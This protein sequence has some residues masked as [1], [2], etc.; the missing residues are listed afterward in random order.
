MDGL[1]PERAYIPVLR[2]FS[3]HASGICFFLK[4]PDTAAC[5]DC[6]KC[7]HKLSP[8]FPIQDIYC[9]VTFRDFRRG[10]PYI[11]YCG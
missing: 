7:F 5:H 3:R 8:I 4:L 1:V 6:L 10:I 2:I 9:Q 11:L